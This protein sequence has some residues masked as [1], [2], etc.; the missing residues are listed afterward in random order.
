MNTLRINLGDFV[1]VE[2]ECHTPMNA[3][4]LSRVV[5]RELNLEVDRCPADWKT[6]GKA[7]GPLRNTE[8]LQKDGGADGVVAFHWNIEES[9]GTA[10]MI[11]QARLAGRPTWIITEGLDE[12]A[13]FI[14]E[15]KRRQNEN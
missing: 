13:R 8:M 15:L 1:V 10:N 3:D 5:A 12:F 9:K 14:L 6:F 2:G 4:K 11:T 7:A